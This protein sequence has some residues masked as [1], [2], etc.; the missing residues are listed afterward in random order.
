MLNIDDDPN[1]EIPGYLA[2]R[3]EIFDEREWSIDSIYR[4]NDL[5]KILVIC[6]DE[7]SMIAV[8]LLNHFMKEFKVLLAIAAL[9]DDGLMWYK[10]N[11]SK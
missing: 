3:D 1:A 5:V 8:Q 10:K 7:F 4:E 9:K 6:N 11:M 2:A